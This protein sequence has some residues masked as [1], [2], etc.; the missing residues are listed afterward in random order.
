MASPDQRGNRGYGAKA[1]VSK[2]SV[3]QLVIL[4]LPALVISPVFEIQTAAAI[5]DN[6]QIRRLPVVQDGRLVG[7]VSR[8][9]LG[10]TKPPVP[11]SLTPDAQ[12]EGD[13]IG[14]DSG[15]AQP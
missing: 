15:G 9:D 5:L 8:G 14:T 11:E 12:Q 3:D 4:S 13:A 2:G 10:A 1:R 6:R 7:I